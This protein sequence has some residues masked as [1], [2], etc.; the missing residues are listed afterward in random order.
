MHYAMTKKLCTTRKYTGVVLSY[1][2]MTAK[3]YQLTVEQQW[4]VS[5]LSRRSNKQLRLQIQEKHPLLQQTGQHKLLLFTV[6]LKNV[7]HSSKNAIGNILQSALTVA[8]ALFLQYFYIM[9]TITICTARLLA[10]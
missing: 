4:P 7:E 3:R 10:F 9:F 1:I 8:W 5:T 2:F 6:P